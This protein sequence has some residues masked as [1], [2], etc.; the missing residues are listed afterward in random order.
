MT[1]P[2]PKIPDWMF[3]YPDAI[4]AL[5]YAAEVHKEQKRKYTE[6]PYVFHVLSVAQRMYEFYNSYGFDVPADMVTAAIL[7]DTVE[8]Q[9]VSFQMLSEHFNMNV[10][11]LVMWLTDMNEPNVKSTRRVR[12]LMCAEKIAWA[13]DS[14]KIIKFFDIADNT[15]SIEKYDP[16]FAKTYLPEKRRILQVIGVLSWA[17]VADTVKYPYKVVE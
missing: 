8:D 16:V 14:A 15:S 12:K 7:H 3:M 13:P 1:V 10:V 2:Q 4:F 11:G 6:E 9:K 5:G 17:R